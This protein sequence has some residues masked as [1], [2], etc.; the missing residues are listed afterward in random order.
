MRIG[1]LSLRASARIPIEAEAAS[2]WMGSSRS[3]ADTPAVRLSIPQVH[4]SHTNVSTVSWAGLLYLSLFLASKFAVAIPFLPPRPYSM[5]PAHTSAIAPSNLKKQRSYSF[6][7]QESHLSSSSHTEE[8]IVPM[9]Y[10]NAAPPVYTLV[11]VLVPVGTAIYICATRFTDFRHF[12]F[13]L[14]FGSLIGITTSWF[15]FRFYHLPI[16]RGAGWAWGPRSYQRAFGVGVGMGSYVGNEG[17]SKSER[18]ATV[19]MGPVEHQSELM[20]EERSSD[21]RFAHTRADAAD[22]V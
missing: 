22:A 16:T 6:H 14:L 1:C 7:K 5:N 17:W 13:D 9:R 8:Q 3:P 10:Q 11:L 21:A 15:S 20:H 19:S 18:S 4:I 12:G 2:L